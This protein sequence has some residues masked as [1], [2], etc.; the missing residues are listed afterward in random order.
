MS[1]YVRHL[2]GMHGEIQI[3]RISF[4]IYLLGL[5]GIICLPNAC[6]IMWG[7]T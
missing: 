6:F 5:G 3:T 7:I 4:V 2:Q 1:T